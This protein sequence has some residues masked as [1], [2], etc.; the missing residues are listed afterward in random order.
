MVCPGWSHLILMKFTL[1][2]EIQVNVMII[3]TKT[4]SHCKNLSNELNDIGIEHKILFAE[5]EPDLCQ[6]LSIRHSP[7]L[8]VDGTVVFRSQPAEAELRRYFKC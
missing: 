3:A 6:E 1:G 7:N 4:C 8:V 5:D 2:E